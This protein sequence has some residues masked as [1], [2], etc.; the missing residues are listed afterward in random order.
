MSVPQD[1]F[2]QNKWLALFGLWAFHGLICSLAIH[3][4]AA[5]DH[6]LLFGISRPRFARGRVVVL[7]ALGARIRSSRYKKNHVVDWKDARFLW[8]A[9]DKDVDC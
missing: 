3:D 6:G 9:G 2:D 5:E 8:K 7:F 1:R 4:P